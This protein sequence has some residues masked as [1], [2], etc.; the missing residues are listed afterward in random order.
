MLDD[1]LRRDLA[2]LLGRGA[3]DLAAKAS[4]SYTQPDPAIEI[5]IRK[6]AGVA[7]AERLGEVG[8]L[9]IVLAHRCPP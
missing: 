9:E 6:R 4:R 8:E 5:R 7:R 2:A 3:R 1:A